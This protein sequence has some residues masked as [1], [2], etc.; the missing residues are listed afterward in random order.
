MPNGNGSSY[1]PRSAKE[2]ARAWQLGVSA[3]GLITGQTE[4]AEFPDAER[5]QDRL[6]GKVL[7]AMLVLYVY[8][9][10]KEG[11]SL[12]LLQRA[13][14]I[15][16]PFP[17]PSSGE[18]ALASTAHRLEEIRNIRDPEQRKEPLMALVLEL[19]DKHCIKSHRELVSDDVWNNYVAMRSNYN[20]QE[21]D[22]NQRVTEWD[23]QGRQ[24]R[25]PQWH[26]Q[27]KPVGPRANVV[28]TITR[29]WIEVYSP[30]QKPESSLLSKLRRKGY[31][32]GT[33]F[34]GAAEIMDMCRVMIMPYA[35]A[36]AEDFLQVLSHQYPPKEV[37]AGETFPRM[38]TEPWQLTQY[39]YFDRKAYV[40]MDRLASSNTKDRTDNLHGMVA[41]IKIVP[42]TMRVAE[43][44]TA[45]VYAALRELDDIA[46]FF[47]DSHSQARAK[48]F[49][50][51]RQSFRLVYNRAKT[52]FDTLCTEEGKSYKFPVFKEKQENRKETYTT[53]KDE[54]VKLQ[55]RINTDAINEARS[56]WPEQ[57]LHTA[58]YQQAD[59]DA[60]T[61]RR[62][63]AE[64]R[65]SGAT[66][67]EPPSSV[68]LRKVGPHLN[69]RHIQ[70]K[71][72]EQWH[73][74]HPRGN[75][76]IALC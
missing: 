72:K 71:A 19:A 3:D 50:E 57:Y 58:Y 65:E 74:D 23:A 46:R 31:E 67:K 12:E 52:A 51:D 66:M 47:P 64:K 68:D 73:K 11:G 35:P 25:P 20:V 34:R 9:E 45:P 37:S 48:K 7:N 42:E 24:G 70:A 13:G 60:T 43:K 39:G 63:K 75:N 26:G 29:K 30:G 18:D 76:G 8:E 27:E 16:P 14:M 2:F 1:A 54:L 69:H 41:E 44:I 17:L 49:S 55:I 21:K 36:V 10:L 4:Q 61:T 5:R 38:F 56:E 6:M 62:E 22:Y 28:N 15:H 32:G 40:A 33:D 53:L 59:R